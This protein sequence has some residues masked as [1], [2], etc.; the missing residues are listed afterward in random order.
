MLAITNN[1]NIQTQPQIQIPKRQID[2]NPFT[3]TH[4]SLGSPHLGKSHNWAPIFVSFPTKTN[5]RK[6]WYKHKTLDV[7]C[8]ISF[9]VYIQIKTQKQYRNENLYNWVVNSRFPSSTPTALAL[10]AL[11]PLWVG[12]GGAVAPLVKPYNAPWPYNWHTPLASKRFVFS[13]FLCFIF[14]MSSSNYLSLNF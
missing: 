4:M 3:L 8:K 9:F 6:F 13:Y 7:A 5:K 2:K 1:L 12:G 10:L 11:P 14:S